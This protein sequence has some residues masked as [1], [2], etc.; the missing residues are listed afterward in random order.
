[1]S[2]LCVVSASGSPKVLKLALDFVLPYEKRC[3]ALFQRIINHDNSVH[4]IIEKGTLN[5]WH[6]LV[7]GVFTYSGQGRLVFCCLPEQT[8]EVSLALTEFFAK[9]S[10]FCISGQ[11]EWAD[12]LEEIVSGIYRGRKSEVHEYHF[13][14]EGRDLEAMDKDEDDFSHRSDCEIIRCSKN[15]I[16]QLMPLQLDYTRVEVL[17]AWREVVP[18]AERISLEKNFKNQFYF[19]VVEKGKIVSKANTNAITKGFFQIGG[20][21]TLEEFRGKGYASALVEHIA[22]EACLLNRKA[23][24]FVKKENAGAIKAYTKAGF[25]ITGGYKIVYYLEK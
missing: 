15:H 18:A 16:E 11:K 22:R 10:V 19:A 21:Y 23:V 24:L 25:I 20:V 13:M 17:P 7:H 8:T 3:C 9:N 6:P 1:M 4:I 5:S 2:A 14:E 12:F